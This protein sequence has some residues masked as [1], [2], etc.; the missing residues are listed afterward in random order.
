MATSS[1]SSRALESAFSKASL[2]RSA[3]LATL[4]SGEPAAISSVTMVEVCSMVWRTIS[5][6][7]RRAG[8]AWKPLRTR[9]GWRR[10]APECSYCWEARDQL[11]INAGELN[12]GVRWI[13][14]GGLGHISIEEWVSLGHLG[15]PGNTFSRCCAGTSVWRASCILRKYSSTSCEHHNK[16]AITPYA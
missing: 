2:T 6:T 10:S 9:A 13:A 3:C 11:H 4:L 15:F 5:R 12:L 8:S 1:A 16:I 7:G 14:F